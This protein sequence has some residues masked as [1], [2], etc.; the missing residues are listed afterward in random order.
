M[1]RKHQKVMQFLEGGKYVAEC[2]AEARYSVKSIGPLSGRLQTS[3]DGHADCWV[4]MFGARRK[5][6]STKG[7]A[8]IAP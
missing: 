7:Q 6:F 4:V 1:A 8:K 5:T 3:T 2:N